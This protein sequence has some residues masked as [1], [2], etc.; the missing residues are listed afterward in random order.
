MM[1]MKT[2]LDGM[3]SV[4]FVLCLCSC[5]CYTTRMNDTDCHRSRCFVYIKYTTNKNSKAYLLCI[6]L[7]LCDMKWFSTYFVRYHFIIEPN[8]LSTI[9]YILYLLMHS[10]TYRYLRSPF[11]Q[12]YFLGFQNSS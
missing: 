5:H 11:S 3:V 4:Y 12:H 1:V 10:T 9:F 8:V 2:M 6:R 7:T